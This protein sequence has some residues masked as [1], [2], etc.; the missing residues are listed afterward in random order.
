LAYHDFLLG[1]SFFIYTDV[2]R[3]SF[4]QTYPYMQMFSRSLWEQDYVTWSFNSGLG[5]N[6]YSSFFSFGDPFVSLCILSGPQ[7]LPYMLG[8]TQFFKP[9]LAGI[10]FFLFLR[11]LKINL[12]ISFI[13]SILY[14]FC[15]DMLAK[16]AWQSYPNVVVWAALAL[17]AI[18]LSISGGNWKWLPIAV[19]I[20]CLSTKGYQSVIYLLYLFVYVIIRYFFDNSFSLRGFGVYLLKH[21]GL[22]ALGAGISAVLLLPG[23]LYGM[24]SARITSSAASAAGMDVPAVISGK[25]A[26][27]TFYRTISIDALGTANT[28]TGVISY[29]ESSLFYCGILPVVVLPQ[30]LFIKNKKQ[31]RII[32]ALEAICLAY[33]VFPFVLYAFNGFVSL[34]YRHSSLFI[35][36]IILF[37]GVITLDN[38]VRTK[39]INIPVLAA[40]CAILTAFVF[41][42]MA[43][44]YYRGYGLVFRM[45]IIAVCVAAIAVFLVLG[46]L[47]KKGRPSPRALFALLLATV[48]FVTCYFS[49]VSVNDGRTTL[50]T[51]DLAHRP[52]TRALPTELRK[53]RRPFTRAAAKSF[54][55][56]KRSTNAATP[57]AGTKRANT[58]H[59]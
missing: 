39:S 41:A 11:R 37:C 7:M 54:S 2:G 56:W 38:I 32:I 57:P 5:Q 45:D 25:E 59:R 8:L 42:G 47:F 52:D 35:T 51:N 16:G 58:V 23:V 43:V 15:G 40:T 48:C 3:D 55:V 34:F 36:I 33:M 10:F 12:N 17:Y 19:C 49:Y 53:R 4:G 50:E 24:E 27:T 46:I 6:L 22:F 14:A 26:L 20:F 29:L 9:I 1:R 44:S 28:F 18:E 30:A 13:I 31:R 21:L